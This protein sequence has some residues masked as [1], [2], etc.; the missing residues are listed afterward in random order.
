MWGRPHQKWQLSGSV[1]EGKGRYGVHEWQVK[2]C[3]P[4]TMRAIPEHFCDEFRLMKRRHTECLHLFFALY[5]AIVSH[6]EHN[7]GGRQLV[8]KS[9][10]QGLG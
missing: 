2:L 3:N 1:W 10:R 6:R 7:T 4:L 9:T 8:S 5:I